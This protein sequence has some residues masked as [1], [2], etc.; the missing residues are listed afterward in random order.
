MVGRA[1]NYASWMGACVFCGRPGRSRE[2]VIEL[3]LGK[4]LK[5][6]RPLAAD[7]R[8]IGL[9][10]RYTPPVGE[11]D[12]AREWASA[13]PDLVTTEVC[14]ECNNGWLARVADGAMPMLCEMVLGR[15]MPLCAEDQ[16]AVAK[17][18]YKTV[19]LMQRAR[20]SANF[21]VIPKERYL[22]LHQV[23]RPPGDV[24][25]W[26][27]V[28]RPVEAVVHSAAEKAPMTTL[29]SRLPGYVA[30]LTVGHLLIVCAGRVSE[31]PQPLLFEARAQGRALIQVW[32]ASLHPAKWPPVQVTDDLTLDGLAELL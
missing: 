6:S 23:G 18:A 16:V 30:V 19:L 31:S 26:L 22:Q 4:A 11:E 9:I 12:T 7:M 2:H 21:K 27:G 1:P 3:Q 10:Q 24:R 15:E 14:V 29:T 28:T 8:R 25:I 13:G 20:P 17:W 5:A 32:P